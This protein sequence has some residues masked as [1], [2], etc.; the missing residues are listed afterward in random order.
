MAF[1]ICIINLCNLFQVGELIG[2]S[3][4]EE[5]YDVIQR[6]LEFNRFNLFTVILKYMVIEPRK[7]LVSWFGLFTLKRNCICKL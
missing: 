2:G 3:Q 4:R 5:R 6:R 7:M 1:D